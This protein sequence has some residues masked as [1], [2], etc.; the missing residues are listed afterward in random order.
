[1][2]KKRNENDVED[3]PYYNIFSTSG[4][5]INIADGTLG[6]G[7]YSTWEPFNETAICSKCKNE[8]QVRLRY[9]WNEDDNLTRIICKKCHT[10]TMDKLY[11]L[12]NN[13]Y[14]EIILYEKNNRK[15]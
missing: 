12:D 1:M 5:T 9:S 3:V 7:V 8:E 13:V 11:E 6:T 15:K 10:K 14:T 4:T 2:S